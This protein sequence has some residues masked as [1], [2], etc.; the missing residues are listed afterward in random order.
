MNKE[1][2]CFVIMPFRPDLHFFYLFLKQHIEQQHQI[3]CERGDAQVLT[4]PIIEKINDY[5]RQADVII[6]DCSGRNPNVF[7]ELGLAHAHDKQVILITHDDVKEAPADIRHYEFIWYQLDKHIEFLERLD[8][9][10]RNVFA[11]QYESLYER[12]KIV[13]AEFCKATKAQVAQA[14]KEKFLQ[15]VFAVPNW[16]LPPIDDMLSVAEFVLPRISAEG[17]DAAVMKQIT[18]W[19]TTQ[20]ND[21]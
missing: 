6:A 11:E 15:R 9:A 7:Y 21:A 1:R 12:A 3:K 20:K 8:N 13:F 14:S 16:Q 5:I 4:K 17:H 18:D 19:L 2:T 10:I